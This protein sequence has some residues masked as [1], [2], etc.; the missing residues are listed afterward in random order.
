MQQNVRGEISQ[1]YCNPAGSSSAKLMVAL[2][3]WLHQYSI[4]GSGMS[5][6]RLLMSV[7]D[8]VSFMVSRDTVDAIMSVSAS[9]RASAQAIN[10][11]YR[12][13]IETISPIDPLGVRR[14]QD[15]ETYYGSKQ[16]LMNKDM[17]S[18][19]SK[20]NGDSRYRGHDIHHFESWKAMAA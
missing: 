17:A 10:R 3:T 4:A 5:F 13:T 6:D 7:C 12:F 2:P 20:L 1:R 16:S 9:A 14:L 15:Y 8:G 11:S 19:V 18:L